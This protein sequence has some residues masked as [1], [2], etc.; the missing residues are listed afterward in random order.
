MIKMALS[1]SL[2]AHNIKIVMNYYLDQRQYRLN[3]KLKACMDKKSRIAKR[4]PA[5]GCPNI[6]RRLFL[7]WEPGHEGIGISGVLAVGRPLHHL[8]FQ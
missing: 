7:V 3:N 6:L 1:K 5:E 2:D 8:F 4:S